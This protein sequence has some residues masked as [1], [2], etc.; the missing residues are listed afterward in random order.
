MGKLLK[1]GWHVLYVKSRHEHKVD[2]LLREV[3]LQ[4]FLPLVKTVR[5]WSD[6]K[7]VIELP[8]FPSYLFVMIENAKDFYKASSINGAC[9]FIKCGSV[10]ATIRDSEIQKIKF[11]LGSDGIEDIKNDTELLEKGEIAMIQ[12]GAFTGLECEILNINNNNKIVVRMDSINQNITAT[13]P[14]HYLSKLSKA[15]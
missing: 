11:L 1:T 8:L 4:P 15:V 13:L 2:N 12:C 6:R 9:T 5:T 7:K 14:S 3:G 10:Y